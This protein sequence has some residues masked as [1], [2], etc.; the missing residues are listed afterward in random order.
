MA[1]ELIDDSSLSWIESRR[2]REMVLR[3]AQAGTPSPVHSEL[4]SAEFPLNL[5]A[6]VLGYPVCVRAVDLPTDVN[7]EIATMSVERFSNLSDYDQRTTKLYVFERD[8]DE[9]V[10]LDAEEVRRIATLLNIPKS[11]VR[12]IRFSTA[13]P[14]SSSYLSALRSVYIGDQFIERSKSFDFVSKLLDDQPFITVS[15]GPGEIGLYPGGGF[16]TRFYLYISG[17]YLIYSKVEGW[18]S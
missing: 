1:D 18:N 6:E 17:Q 9:S 10:S 7:A 14:E 2:D 13:S 16:G 11:Y 15:F 12:N 4:C 8:A 5:G 3:Y